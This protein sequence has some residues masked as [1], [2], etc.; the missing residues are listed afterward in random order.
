V[1][2]NGIVERGGDEPL[3]PRVRD[4][5]ASWLTH[6]VQSRGELE[7]LL[8]SKASRGRKLYPNMLHEAL[9]SG[10]VEE[11][12]AL[13]A[14]DGF[15]P[16]YEPDGGV[17]LEIEVLGPVLERDA[18]GSPRLRWFGSDSKTKNGHSVVLRMK[19]RDVS[20]LLGGDLN[21]PAEHFLLSYHTGYPLPTRTEAEWDAMLRGAREKFRSDVAKACHHGSADFTDIFL[22]AVDPIVTVVSS[23]DA[24]PHAHPRADSL[25][26]VG[27]WGRGRRP[28]VFST[29]LARS[30]PEMIAHPHVLRTQ[31]RDAQRRIDEAAEGPARDKA[32]AVLDKILD[33]IDRSVAVFGAI[34]LRTDGRR[35][36]MGQKI[37]KYRDPG[38]K[39]DIYCLEPDQNGILG[40]VSKH[41]HT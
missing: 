20:I 32:K 41:E 25:G 21:I 6:V 4:G 22:Q 18:E 31:I 34:N 14:D 27:R 36:V 11:F 39:W 33:R 24:E 9:T 37:E 23:G 30:A 1:Y 10:R 7:R 13:S 2:H 12:R 8:N 38:K 35:I 40:Y 16:G 3:G 26:A 29:E 5:R 15:L 28:L 17:G 19:Y